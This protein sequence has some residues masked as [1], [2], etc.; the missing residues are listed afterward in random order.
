M[1][2]YNK[3]DLYKSLDYIVKEH[4]EYEKSFEKQLYKEN[5]K[6]WDRSWEE[7]DMYRE[8]LEFSGSVTPKKTPPAP[9]SLSKDQ[10]RS[11]KPG[12]VIHSTD[13]LGLSAPFCGKNFTVLCPDPFD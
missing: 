13:H 12:D 4:L 1:K 2:R 10:I 3:K 8:L 7:R 6:S 5:Y 9:M 11:L